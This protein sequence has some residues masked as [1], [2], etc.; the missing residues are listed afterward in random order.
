MN[1]L[2]A[3][4]RMQYITD[5][6]P[7]EPGCFLCNAYNDKDN[8]KKHY[9]LMRNDKAYIILN[10]YPYSCGHL[11]V[12]PARHF[13]EID[14]ACVD[15]MIPLWE[16]TAL[17]KK[18]LMSAIGAEG[19]NIGVNQGKCAGTGYTDHLH[20]HIVPRWPGDTNFMSVVAGVR[21]IPQALDET[22]DVLL[23]KLADIQ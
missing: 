5:S 17:C 2:W 19:V 10:R 12:V 3:P 15:E 4:W 9:V 13:G 6:A 11:M 1:N 23:Q 21:I 16:L 20:I 14:E 18:L 7:K 22:Y 8:N